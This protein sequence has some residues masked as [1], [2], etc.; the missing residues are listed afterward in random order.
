M[1]ALIVGI[2]LCGPVAA[3]AQITTPKPKYGV[4]VEQEKNVDFAKFKTY[5]WTTGQPSVSK[6]IDG[7]IVA[8]VD[9]EMAGAGF[10]KAAS[11]SGDVMVA[12]Y[13]LSRTDVDLKAKPDASGARPQ[14][15]VGTLMVALLEP[16]SRKRLVRMRIDT[17]I[18]TDSAGLEA[19]INRAVTEL[20]AE[21]PGRK[22]K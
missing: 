21:Y 4:K 11:G 2:A 15:D 12:Y 8:A 18:E 10:S 19:S 22:R 20:F 13:S 16:S 5:S 7:Q 9:R 3:L 17:P 14:Y 6:Q 1:K